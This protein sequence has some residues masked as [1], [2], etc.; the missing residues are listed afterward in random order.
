MLIGIEGIVCA[1]K[2]TLVAEL[3][4]SHL[5]AVVEEYGVFTKGHSNFPHFPPKNIDDIITADKYFIGI[6]KMR[7]DY[8]QSLMTTDIHTHIVV[9]RTYHSCLAFDY[10]VSKFVDFNAMEYSTKCWSDAL[11]IEP[12]ITIILDIDIQT[13]LERNKKR[14]KELFTHFKNRSF[15]K[16]Q[17]DYYLRLTKQDSTHYT[18]FNGGLP[19]EDIAQCVIQFIH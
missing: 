13:M 14:N 17:R 1:G 10:A 4:K 18:I 19:T 15:C 12:H 8:L 3:C 5:F 7:Y 6:E 9:D 2:S 16:S 11:K